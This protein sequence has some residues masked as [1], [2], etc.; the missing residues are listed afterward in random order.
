MGAHL[1]MLNNNIGEL[2]TLHV[3]R[4]ALLQYMKPVHGLPDVINFRHIYILSVWSGDEN[5]IWRKFNRWKFYRRK[6]PDERVLHFYCVGYQVY[7][8]HQNSNIPWLVVI[9]LDI[10][11]SSMECL[12][13]DWGIQYHAQLTLQYEIYLSSKLIILFTFLASPALV[14][15]FSWNPCDSS[16]LITNLQSINML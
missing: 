1:S 9:N 2:L 14:V 3:V 12:I 15:L 13:I 5:I 6:F 11:H 4:M 10:Q 16:D 7:Y 8:Y